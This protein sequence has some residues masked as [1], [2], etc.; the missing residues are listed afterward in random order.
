MKNIFIELLDTSS[1]FPHAKSDAVPQLVFHYFPSKS[2]TS[3][4][5]PTCP[6]KQVKL[7]VPPKQFSGKFKQYSTKSERLCGLQ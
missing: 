7:P 2:H 3:H 4:R 6:S 5:A 1:H